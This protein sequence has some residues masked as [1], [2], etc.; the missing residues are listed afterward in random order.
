MTRQRIL[1]ALVA[2]VAV[3]VVGATMFLT[4]RPA[5]E[6]R[7]AAVVNGVAIP[8][9]EYSV[10]VAALEASYASS[11]PASERVERMTELK[12]LVLDRLIDLEL[13]RQLADRAGVSVEA[14]EIDALI[15]DVRSAWGSDAAFADSLAQQ[16]LTEETYRADLELQLLLERYLDSVAGDIEATVDEARALYGANTGAYVDAQGQ[17]LPFEEV[18][19]RIRSALT[20]QKRTDAYRDAIEAFRAES[21]ITVK[22]SELAEAY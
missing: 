15:D 1:A 4:D 5:S 10:P 6:P 2:L 19:E 22:V 3:V 13:A 18:R 21:E 12:K 14:A 20:L 16:G 17:V 11:Y 7:D 9:E 8:M